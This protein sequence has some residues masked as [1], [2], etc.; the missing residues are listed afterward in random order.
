MTSSSATPETKRATVREVTSDD[1]EGVASL[2]RALGLLPRGAREWEWIWEQNPARRA[3]GPSG[4]VLERDGE[5]G[6]YIG[7]VPLAYRFRDTAVR[8]VAAT[9]FAVAPRFRAH[10]LQLTSQFF[11]QPDVDLCLITTANPQAAKVF[12]AFRARP[13]PQPHIETF[14]FW[15]ADPRRFVAAAVRRRGYARPLAYAAGLAAGPLV[16][17]EALLRGRGPRSPHGSLHVEQLGSSEIGAEF[18]GLFAAEIS[19]RQQLLRVRD[20]QQLRW[21]LSG[22]PRMR[23]Y[24]VFCARREG[25]LVGY[26]VAWN[27]WVDDLGLM[28]THLVDLFAARDDPEVVDHLLWQVCAYTRSSRSH[29]LELRGFPPAVRDRFERLLP[30]QRP[31]GGSTSL[32]RVMRKDLRH[33]LASPSAWYATMLDGD[34]LF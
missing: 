30:R 23:D 12:G 28:R 27:E 5:I 11:R 22:D 1:Q 3:A 4:W 6:G 16:H 29:V 14:L 10:T 26:C 31:T 7:T 24:R 21:Q 15:V 13:I 32:V 17:L 9:A 19:H 8:V 20:S 25:Q 2:H 18:D 33:V 34:T